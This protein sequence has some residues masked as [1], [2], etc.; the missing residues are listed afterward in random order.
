MQCI[1][2][3]NAIFISKK[4]KHELDGW[5][6][7]K[8][9]RCIRRHINISTLL[10]VP[11]SFMGGLMERFSFMFECVFTRFLFASHTQFCCQ[12]SDVNRF[13]YSRMLLYFV[14]VFFR[15][16]RMLSEFLS[17]QILSSWDVI[18]SLRFISNGIMRNQT[19]YLNKLCTRT[20][21]YQQFIMFE[22]R[23]FTCSRV[24]VHQPRCAVSHLCSC[25]RIRL[26][27]SSPHK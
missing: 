5:D 24:I 10:L 12:H 13:Q 22:Y 26:L 17:C 27:C 15:F 16:V 7:W 8:F 20:F 6:R 18:S 2:A 4:Y 1:S 3:I 9:Y 23:H 19:R 21:R 11:V 25:Y 14:I